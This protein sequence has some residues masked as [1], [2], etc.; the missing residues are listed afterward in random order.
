M[1]IPIHQTSAVA[2]FHCTGDACPDTCCK[3][4]GMQLTQETVAL[5]KAEAPELLDAVTSGEAEFIMRRDPDTDFCVKFDAGWC[6]VHKAYGDRMLGD[7]CHFF[8]RITRSVAGRTLMT[9]SMGCPEITRLTLTQDAP[10]SLIDAQVERVPFSLKEYATPELDGEVIWMLHHAFVAHVRTEGLAAE[11]ALSHV[12]S[13]VRSMS[14]LPVE[15]W[16]AA[17]GFYLRMADGRLP[18]PEAQASDPFNILNALQGL[19][20]AAPVAKRERL[21]RSIECMAETMRVGLDWSALRMHL[22]EGADVAYLRMQAFWRE[23]CAQHYAPILSRWLEGQLSLSLFPFAGLGRDMVER[24]TIIGVRFAT[25]KLALMAACFKAQALLDEDELVRVVQGISRFMDHLADP[26]LSMRIY[27][28]VGWV[29]EA[30]LRAL[31]GDS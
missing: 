14:L 13:V 7:A 12:A 19:V 6:G 27:D 22:G 8:P 28:E 11:R 15:Q 24:I 9:A 21:M 2:Q 25:V 10:A 17:I 18:A 31:I 5:Y 20:G 16:T 1:T 29:R 30:R 4:W 23:H 3:G 26:E